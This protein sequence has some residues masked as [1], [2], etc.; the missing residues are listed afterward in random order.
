MTTL[1]QHM[2]RADA[3]WT[4][5]ALST[6]TLRELAPDERHDAIDQVRALMRARHWLYPLVEA[7]RGV[8]Q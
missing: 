4:K 7:R 5:L 1:A 8:P 3:A 2:A 6:S